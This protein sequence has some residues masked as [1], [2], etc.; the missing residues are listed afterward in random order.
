M[1]FK[2]DEQVRS[3]K[4]DGSSVAKKEATDALATQVF[5]KDEW[6]DHEFEWKEQHVKPGFARPVM[7]HRAILGSVERFMAILI[8]HLGGKWPFFISPRQV[9]ICPISVKHLDY[10]RSVFLYLHKQGYQCSID[11]SND[12]LNKKIRNNQLA[13]YNFILV[14]GEDEE[15]AGTV[16]V[17]TRENQRLGKMRVDI[18]HTYFQSLLP[19][20]SEAYNKF[21]ENAWDPAHYEQEGISLSKGTEK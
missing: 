6:D 19:P 12:T 17:R 11:E 15:A 21:Y 13:Q 16:D 2:T 9:V 1:Q 18:L 5:C 10:C 7:I 14:A 4:S 8:E 3:V 20:K